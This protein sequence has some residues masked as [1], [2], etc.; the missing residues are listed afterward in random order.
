MPIRRTPAAASRAGGAALARH[1][2]APQPSEFRGDAPSAS[3][4]AT[5]SAFHAAAAVARGLTIN[6]SASAPVAKVVAEPGIE[7]GTNMFREATGHERAHLVP[8]VLDEEIR[9]VVARITAAPRVQLLMPPAK[10]DGDTRDVGQA[11]R[12]LCSAV[13]LRSQPKLLRLTLLAPNRRMDARLHGVAAQEVKDELVHLIMED[14][15]ALRV[16]HPAVGLQ[17]RLSWRI[18]HETI[19][20]HRLTPA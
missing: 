3:T 16:R 13:S 20:P 7:P 8:Q 5:P 18:P 10:A 2:L 12:Q 11:E 1:E 4:D 9:I 15:E 19:V 14:P 17:R 6:L